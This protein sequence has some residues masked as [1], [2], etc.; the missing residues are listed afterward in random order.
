[1]TKLIHRNLANIY[2]LFTREPFVSYFSEEL[3]YYY[4]ERGY[5]GVIAYD[6]TD[7]DFNVIVLSRDD[8]LQFRAID[9]KTSIETL[10]E[11]RE[12]LK[13]SINSNKIIK[14]DTVEFFDI[15]REK[16]RPKN[17]HPFFLLL[18][19]N[20]EY[21]SAKEVLKEISY[22]YKDIDGNFIDQ[23]QSINGFDARLWEIFL[24]CLFRE[25]R[26]SFNRNND[27]PDFIVKKLEDEI[28][29]EAVIISRKN[30]SYDPIP[31][32][33]K[34]EMLSRIN[35][36]VPLMI[37]NAIYTKAEKKYWDKPHVKDKPFMIA[38]ADFHD[39]ASMTW[40]FEGFLIA[41]YGVKVKNSSNLNDC[42]ERVEFLEKPN[43]TKINAGL[44]LDKFYENISAIIYNP[45]GTISK[46]NRL[47]K[48]ANL[49]D[50]TNI[51]IRSVTFHN[52]EEGAMMPIVY[53]YIVDEKYSENWSEGTSIF[54]NPN[55][56]I[57][58]DPN[59]F[60]D[61][62]AQHFWENDKIRSFIPQFHAYQ[63]L[64]TNIKLSKK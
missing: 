48:Q 52:H 23:F 53:E 34:E 39:T 19:N 5:L 56:K 22:H 9:T 7:D 29:I 26:F 10:K 31:I 28:A 49:G 38:I 17:I 60:D 45:T 25:Q 55:A 63:N 6:Y 40:S 2:L 3:E 20:K 62:I 21:S 43:G 44:L 14:H 46:F 36:E 32:P 16:K 59:L 64:T 51:L 61:N 12:T 42:F 1:M 35:N 37:C 4:D 41:L 15:F 30:K 57:P 11:A 50:I 24:F 8:S 13:D 18:D 33:S 54:H 47:G 27:S 58:L